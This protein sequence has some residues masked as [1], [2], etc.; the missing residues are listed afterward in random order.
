MKNRYAIVL[1]ILAFLQT[2]AAW[3]QVEI[4]NYKRVLT[5]NRTLS[6]GIQSIN[7]TTG[8][9]VFGGGDSRGPSTPFT[10]IWGDGTSTNG[11]FP[12][13]KR[14]ADVSKNYLTKVIANYSATEKDTVEVLVNFTKP[15][16]TPTAL[17][18][19]LKVFIPSQPISLNIP[20]PQLKPF[21]DSFFA[22]L[23]RSDFEYLFQVGATI[24]YEF[25]NEN[26]LLQNG[27]FE[28][29]ALRDT[30]T[31]NAYALWFA[32]PVTFAIGDGFLQGSDTDFSSMYH[33]MG[34]N[35]TL[36]FPA[37]FIFG[38][39]I[40]GNANAIFSE[41]I[42]QIF[43][44]SAGYEVINNYKF[45]GLD[46]V[47][48]FKYKAIFSRNMATTFGFYDQ[49]LKG[50]KAFASWNNPSTPTDETL[51]TFGTIAY[52]FCEYAE[53]QG[54]GYRQPVKRMTQFLSRFNAEWKNRYDQLN[55][56]P[57]ANSFRA[58]MMVSA[59]S[60]AFQKDLRADFRTLNFPISDSDW[61]FLNPQLLD[62]SSTALAINAAANSTAMVEVASNVAWTVSSSQPWLTPNLTGS[63]GNKTV[64]LTAAA[65]PGVTPRSAT[66]T[67]SASGLE[68][69]VITVTQAGTAPTL[70]VSRNALPI[71]ATGSEKPTVELTSNTSWTASSSQ[72]WLTVT[73][74]AGSGNQ[75]LTVGAT[76]N[77]SVSP[78]TAVLTLSASG[79]SSQIVTVTQAG[80]TPVLTLS[81]TSLNVNFAE[82]STAQFEVA[83]NAG[84]TASSSETWL[85]VSPASGSDNARL[86]VMAALNAAYT[87]RKATVTVRASGAADKTVEVTQAATPITS[88]PTAP[89]TE[90]SVFPNPATDLLQIVG[91]PANGLVRIYTASGRLVKEL[92]S[93]VQTTQLSLNDLPNGLYLIHLVSGDR[94][95]STKVFKNQ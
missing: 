15:K 5:G 85:T 46:E 38:G 87:P 81:T 75:T 45:Y 6:A 58:T 8:E 63:D 51:F 20:S 28:Q 39:K 57:A 43:Q 7:R 94:T 24:E 55:D 76:P 17:D 13:T 30:T 67:V 47:L 16:I 10:W 25:L 9:V 72:A 44:H 42:A 69:R 93:E 1:V 32:R 68:P 71:N 22:E 84:W 19:K 26:V 29:Y 82:G 35:L 34:H 88:L 11:F 31:K 95:V 27:K 66:V 74:A 91:L 3:A 86:T 53:Q 23:S 48:F 77:A 61:T 62:V 64:T 12:Q 54:R 73:P 14:Y 90:L 49:Y 92:R 4:F 21:T 59:L 89:G 40:D 83:S 37:N 41:A 78:R 33:E 65:N 70:T 18:P 80:A 52:K 56:T 2:S 36:N 60:H 79:V 50:G